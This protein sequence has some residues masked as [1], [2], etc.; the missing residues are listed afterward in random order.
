MDGEE[1]V[2]L[3]GNI[4]RKCAAFFSEIDDMITLE[5]FEH[6]ENRLR[7][8]GVDAKEA[9]SKVVEG[10]L[11]G[12][13]T[14][15]ESLKSEEG[16]EL[17]EIVRNSS[18]AGV[19]D[20]QSSQATHDD[21]DTKDI[22]VEASCV[23]SVDDSCST[24]QSKK[25]STSDLLEQCNAQSREVMESEEKRSWL[26][27]SEDHNPTDCP[28][29]KHRLKKRVHTNESELRDEDFSES[30]SQDEDFCESESQDED[31]CESDWVIV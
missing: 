28:K 18:S 19:E 17:V 31:V 25:T 6:A 11:P 29:K 21:V 5:S 13:L 22:N 16:H 4:Y 20:N 27:E 15:S 26:I 24:V 8:A 2:P 10:I 9:C 12:F 30:E 3:L 23:L 14:V 7:I 1:I